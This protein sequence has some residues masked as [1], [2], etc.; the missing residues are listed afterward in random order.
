VLNQF[1]LHYQTGKPIPQA[2]VDKIEAA[3]KFNQ[4]FDTTE[5]LA[6]ALI[7]MKLHLAGDVDI[8]PDKFERE[9]LAKLNMPHGDR[10]AAP[11]AAVRARVL[12]ATAIRPAT[13]AICGPTP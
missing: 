2:L 12:V 10:H 3:D 7:D 8:D 4:G 13:T 11:H 9:E 1:A 5:Y 6:S